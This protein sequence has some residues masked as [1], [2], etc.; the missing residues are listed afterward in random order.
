[1]PNTKVIYLTGAQRQAKYKEKYPDRVRASARNQMLKRKY[2]ITLEAYDAMLKE[3]GGVCAICKQENKHKY[4][5][6]VDH[7]HTTG[8]IRGILCHNCNLILG[9]AKD[10]SDILRAAIGYL[11]E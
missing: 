10:N 4:P 8:K 9:N 1:M 3:Q 6:P 2:G 7:C 5:F 11:D